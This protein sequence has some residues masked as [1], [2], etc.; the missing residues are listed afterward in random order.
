M[1]PAAAGRSLRTP[2]AV[3]RRER[4]CHIPAEVLR[5]SP[6]AEAAENRRS[7]PAAGNRHH[8]RRRRRHSRPAAGILNRQKMK[9]QRKRVSEG[10]STSRDQGSQ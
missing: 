7:R 1:A 6:A 4:P 8:S 10:T 3:G 5:S 9:I 2:E